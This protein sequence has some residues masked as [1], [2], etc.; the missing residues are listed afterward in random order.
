[1]APEASISAASTRPPVRRIRG[2]GLD[3]GDFVSGLDGLEGLAF[4]RHG[5]LHASSYSRNTVRKYSPSGEDLGEFASAH[6]NQPYGLAFDRAEELEPFLTEGA[7][8]TLATRVKQ[9][10]LTVLAA[11]RA[12]LE[13]AC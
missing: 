1:M 5:N 8:E 6:L 4:D 10:A 12:V 11:A 9:I 3:L 2:T 13:L 7:A